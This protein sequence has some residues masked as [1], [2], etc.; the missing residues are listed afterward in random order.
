MLNF[1]Q[2]RPKNNL[3]VENHSEGTPTKNGIILT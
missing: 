2:N 3:I 1:A